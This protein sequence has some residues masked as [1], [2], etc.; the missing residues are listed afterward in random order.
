MTEET[1]CGR[2]LRRVDGTVRLWLR[3]GTD[4]SLTRDANRLLTRRASFRMNSQ[5]GYLLFLSFYSICLLTLSSRSS[6]WLDEIL[7]LIGARMDSAAAV[8]LYAPRNSAGVPLGYLAQFATVKLLGYSAFAGRL[9]C[10]IFSV[11]SCAGIFVL[12]RRL[13][14]KR[15]LLR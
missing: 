10:A 9:P 1:D 6:L 5:R 2:L 3:R 13:R 12:A 8:V 11:V 15:P 4:G 7:D 14:L